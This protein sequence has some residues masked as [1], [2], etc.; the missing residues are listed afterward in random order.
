MRRGACLDTALVSVTACGYDAS[1]GERR[2]GVSQ[3]GLRDEARVL[4][5]ADDRFT[6]FTD[7]TQKDVG[8]GL[9]ARDLL[10][11]AKEDVVGLLDNNGVLEVLARLLGQAVVVD[12]EEQRLDQEGLVGVGEGVQLQDHAAVEEFGYAERTRTV[13]NVPHLPKTE[14][15][16]GPHG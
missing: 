14:H 2:V 3:G 8:H 16:D 12:P 5:Q 15:L 13:E 4:V 9:L 1:E 10:L 11:L 6:E 7:L